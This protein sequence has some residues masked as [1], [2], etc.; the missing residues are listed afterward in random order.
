MRKITLL[1]IIALIG[2]LCNLGAQTQKNPKRFFIENSKKKSVQIPFK[3]LNNLVVLPVFVNN[4]DTLQFI[5]DSGISNTIITDKVLATKLNM[6]IIKELKMYGFGG[7]SAVTALHSTEN[8]IRIP[9]IAG[10]HQD[11]VVIPNPDYDFSK[12]LG[13]KIHGLLGYNVFRDLIVEINYDAKVVTFNTPK[14]YVYKQ[15]KNET[16]LPLTMIDTKPFV[17]TSFVQEDNTRIEGRFLIDSGASF[18]LWLDLDSDSTIRLP[19]RTETLYLGTGLGGAVHGLVGRI[20]EFGTGKMRLQNVIAS[21]ADTALAIPS[22]FPD[23]R[24]GTIG[25]DILS[26]FH[27]IFDYRNNKITLRP[28]SKTRNPFLVN[29]SGMEI[30]CPTPGENLFS[31]SNISYNSPAHK[32]GLK[33]GDQIIHINSAELSKMSLPDIHAMLLKHPGKKMNVQYKRNGRISS[34][35]LMMNNCI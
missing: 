5:L 25:A 6:Q 34:A 22:N 19:Q 21:Y 29:Q 8:T 11:I 13:I 24:N 32:A 18:A 28:N 1:T 2:L 35:T 14:T 12:L 16:V 27:V 4:S 17:T 3:L 33:T 9:G 23:K 7:G 10:Y 20:R 15:R 30:C 31:I 26:R